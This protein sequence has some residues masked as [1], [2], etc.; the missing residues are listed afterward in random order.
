MCRNRYR[1]V[2]IILKSAFALQQLVKLVTYL[3]IQIPTTNQQ[4]DGLFSWTLKR[5]DEP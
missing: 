2:V 3:K 1:D 5:L 4:L